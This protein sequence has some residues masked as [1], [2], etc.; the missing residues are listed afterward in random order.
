MEKVTNSIRKCPEC[1]SKEVA[2]NGFN[3]GKQTYKC[4]ICKRSF[5]AEIKKERITKNKFK[6]PEKEKEYLIF[7]QMVIDN[8]RFIPP[9]KILCEKIKITRQ[10]VL[11]WKEKLNNEGIEVNNRIPKEIAAI[12]K[13]KWKKYFM[14]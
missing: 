4:K 9:Y 5:F 10:T 11:R 6:S 1:K 8:N 13:E 3:K 7:K 2:K 14:E 12:A